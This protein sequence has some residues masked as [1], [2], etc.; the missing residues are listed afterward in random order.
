MCLGSPTGGSGIF[1][2]SNFSV[3]WHRFEG[4]QRRLLPSTRPRL[5]NTLKATGIKVGLLI[6][7]GNPKLETKRFTRHK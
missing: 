2:I 4:L 1:W 6:H 5:L 7:F 3:R